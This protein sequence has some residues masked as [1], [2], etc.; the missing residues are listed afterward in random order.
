[1]GL[2]IRRERDQRV[3]KYSRATV[4]SRHIVRDQLNQAPY[5]VVRPPERRNERKRRP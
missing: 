5:L 2:P 1:M 4:T 3:G